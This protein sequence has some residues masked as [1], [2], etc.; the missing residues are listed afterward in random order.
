MQHFSIQKQRVEHLSVQQLAFHF[1][2]W[3]PRPAGLARSRQRSG[4]PSG[5]NFECILN[6]TGRTQTR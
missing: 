6:F 5:W 1:S 2:K 3:L 4:R